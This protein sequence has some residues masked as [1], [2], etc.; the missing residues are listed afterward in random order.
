MFFGLLQLP[1][2]VVSGD[3]HSRSESPNDEA[4]QSELNRMASIRLHQK[5]VQTHDKQWPGHGSEVKN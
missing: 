1:D 3:K 2:P 4:R 5:L